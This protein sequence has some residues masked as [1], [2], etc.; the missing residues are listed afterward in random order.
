MHSVG[1]SDSQ[2][3]P[4]RRNCRYKVTAPKASYPAVNPIVE[5]I[6]AAPA[7]ST[8]G[9]ARPTA[10]A[11]R[12]RRRPERG[13]SNLA[14]VLLFLIPMIAAMLLLDGRAPK[15][16]D[17]GF[18]RGWALRLDDRLG[19][20]RQALDT[21]APARLASGG[22]NGEGA[23][24]PPATAAIA[25]AHGDLDALYDA[26]LT[27][28]AGARDPAEA[29]SHA[30]A[31]CGHYLDTATTNWQMATAR[32]ADAAKPAASRTE[33]ETVAR[34]RDTAERAWRDAALA[35]RE[36]AEGDFWR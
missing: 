16:A 18:E 14:L 7:S 23:L 15:R 22:E 2:G 35:C 3:A 24:P 34:L 25:G 19:P 30:R 20:L 33:L 1:K 36:I 29:R 17:A 10:A 27:I 31:A 26:L 5:T 9:R 8:G 13:S 28:R 4:R 6:P 32:L 12:R 21:L 11:P